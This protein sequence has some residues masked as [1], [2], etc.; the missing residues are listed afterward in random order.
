[1]KEGKQGETNTGGDRH[2]WTEVWKSVKW[3]WIIGRNVDWYKF[4]EEQFW[5]GF[6]IT[7]EYS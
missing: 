7:S 3:E 6:L 2:L 5:N 1:M 4:P